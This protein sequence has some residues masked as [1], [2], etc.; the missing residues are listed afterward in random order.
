MNLLVRGFET[1]S[2]P[3]RSTVPHALRIQVMTAAGSLIEQSIM[4]APEA[5]LSVTDRPLF[6]NVSAGPKGGA[7]VDASCSHTTADLVRSLAERGFAVLVAARTSTEAERLQWL[8]AGADDCAPPAWSIPVMVDRLRAILARRAAEAIRQA[9]SG[10]C[11]IFDDWLFDSVQSVLTAPS[12]RRHALGRAG[13]QV[14]HR[15]LA[16]PHKF[17]TLEE[18]GQHPTQGLSA[19]HAR[20]A[21]SRLRAIL[22]WESST[23]III[24]LPRRGYRLAVPVTTEADGPRQARSS[25]SR[26]PSPPVGILLMQARTARRLSQLELAL[27]AGISTRHL[28][29]LETGRSRPTRTMVLRLASALQ[30]PDEEATALVVAAGL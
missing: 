30:L 17:L 6:L 22:S 23:E 12:G 11:Y 28:S 8:E 10:W 16:T 7:L 26:P 1:D 9:A 18:L 2:C 13:A 21:V 29:F 3:T 14:L 15:L 20:V 27:E 19:N 4:R 25:L 5:D 24:T